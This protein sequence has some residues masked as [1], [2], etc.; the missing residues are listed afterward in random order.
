MKLNG[1]YF[2]DCHC[3]KCII[4]FTNNDQIQYLMRINIGKTEIYTKTYVIYFIYVYMNPKI[5][6]GVL[7]LSNCI[8]S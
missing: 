5:V 8:F 3:I 7:I 4:A 1:P 6:L 2:N